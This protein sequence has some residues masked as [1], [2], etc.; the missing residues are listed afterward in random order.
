MSDISPFTN[1]LIPE[2]TEV[3]NEPAEI[4]RVIERCYTVRN[5]SFTQGK[6]SSSR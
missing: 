3:L 1:T 4:V 6:L 5:T 2:K